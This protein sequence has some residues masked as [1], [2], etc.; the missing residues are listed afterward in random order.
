MQTIS[1]E[2]DENDSLAT[3]NG[4]QLDEASSPYNSAVSSKNEQQ[5]EESSSLNKVYSFVVKLL[6]LS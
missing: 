5:L 1:D 6:Y 3:P 4:E 2:C